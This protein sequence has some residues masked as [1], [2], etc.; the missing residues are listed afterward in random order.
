MSFVAVFVAQ[1]LQYVVLARFLESTALGLVA[2]VTLINGL[3]E[4]FLGM[5]ISQAVIQRSRISSRE[6]SS[7]FWLNLFVGA[8]IAAC[9]YLSSALV[10]G[11]FGTPDAAHLI[12]LS[13]GVF[14][15][16]SLGQVHRATL[17][18]RLQFKQVGIIETCAAAIL[19]ASTLTFAFNG[20]EAYSAVFGLIL[21][22]GFRSVAMC[23]IGKR[24][25]RP[26]WHFRAAETKR[27]FSF[28]LLQTADSLLTYATS[29]IGTIAI[30]RSVGASQMGGYNLAYNAAVNMPSRINPI[31]TRIMFPVFATIQ[32]DRERM[33]ANY[34]KVMIVAGLA[35]IPALA[36]LA[37][38]SSDFVQAVYGEKWAWIAP[39]IPILCIVGMLR[40]LGNPVGF[41]LLATDN[42]VLSLVMN[43]VK[44]AIAIPLVAVG[45]SI[46]GT[47]G[48]AYGLLISQ[49]AS[50]AL[51]YLVL[52]RV[53]GI[54]CP[55]YLR[56]PAIA[57]LVSLPMGAV[58][59][60][61]S[62]WASTWGLGTW[63]SLAVKVAVGMCVLIAT[64]LL[65][66]RPLLAELGFSHNRQ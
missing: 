32:R 27:F 8:G 9:V 59:V 22:T 5:G 65:A 64:L 54:S 48:A 57:I 25:F 19:L 15:L 47:Y 31:V 40:S 30:G 7:L 33:A 36:G 38:V 26:R 49:I 20:Y 37:I 18:K 14:V 55:R 17:E 43:A 51:T 52:R 16:S 58:L 24:Y 3:A 56:A 45:A 12:Q 29:N 53:L 62:L 34:E 63:L 6:L 23:L 13:A 35:S 60:P 42:M 44:A 50:F 11:F 39:L 41:V 10:A 1:F 61:I 46:A 4:I 21:S 66:K 2:I 28:G